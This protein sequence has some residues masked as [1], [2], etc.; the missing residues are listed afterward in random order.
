M[1]TDRLSSRLLVVSLVLIM[2]VGVLVTPKNK[3]R[4][5]PLT[6]VWDTRH[7]ASAYTHSFIFGYLT[8]DISQ[9][10]AGAVEL[11]LRPSDSRFCC[12]QLLLQIFR[13]MAVD[14]PFYLVD[15]FFGLVHFPK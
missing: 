4:L 10:F 8:Q 14:P 7:T 1:A 3:V 2:P 11:L 9:N 12:T 5:A 6:F 13:S 15:I